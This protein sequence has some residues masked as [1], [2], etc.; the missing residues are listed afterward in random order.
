MAAADGGSKSDDDIPDLADYTGPKVEQVHLVS[1][2]L[3]PGAP[4]SWTDLIWTAGR[5][6]GAW[7]TEHA[8]VNPRSGP[9]TPI[10][11]PNSGLR[12]NNS[13]DDVH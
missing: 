8:S 9:S 3:L 2:P 1:S 13:H 7:Q 5:Q 11:V 12:R 10:Q 6:P 4:C